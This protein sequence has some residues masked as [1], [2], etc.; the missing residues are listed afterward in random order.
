MT[1]N[2]D[3][4]IRLF[5]TVEQ[6]LYR[7]AVL[8]DLVNQKDIDIVGESSTGVETLSLLDMSAPSTLIIEEN[9]KD[10]D[11]LTIA[12]AALL[13]IPSLVVILLVDDAISQNRLAI[14]LDSG[15]KS[16][17]SKKQS[18][19]DLNKSLN[20]TRNGHVYI[21]GERYRNESE[22]LKSQ[23]WKVENFSTELFQLL[24]EREQEVAKYIADHIPLK[25]I[26]EELGVSHKTVHTYKERI[27]I[28]LGFERLPE[29]VVYMKRLHFY[30][31][32]EGV[33]L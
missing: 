19:Q 24:S 18:L 6:R 1:F 25:R 17:V 11:G 8:F 23:V 5:I 21:D 15:I 14:Y 30:S 32:Q 2:I 31:L 28:K 27:L 3:N 4:K 16:V 20:Y 7:D 12:E 10:M 22:R 9:L 29:L 33:C 26:A 13:K